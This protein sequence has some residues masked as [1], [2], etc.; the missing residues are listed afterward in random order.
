MPRKSLIN[1]MGSKGIKTQRGDAL[2]QIQYVY[3]IFVYNLYR[4][5]VAA[6]MGT[7]LVSAT[8]VSTGVRKLQEKIQ[9]NWR[10]P[11]KNPLPRCV[12][13]PTVLCVF[14]SEHAF[15]VLVSQL[16][17]TLH[18]PKI[19]KDAT[20]L[21]HIAV[22][23]MVSKYLSKI[24][25]RQ[26]IACNK[27]TVS[28]KTAQTAFNILRSYRPLRLL[29]DDLPSSWHDRFGAPVLFH[30]SSNKSSASNN[31]ANGLPNI[32]NASSS[33]REVPNK[34][35]N[36]PNNK[37]SHK[38]NK[39]P[40][41]PNNKTPNKPNNKNRNMAPS[42]DERSNKK[43]SPLPSSSSS[44][45][46][47]SSASSLPKKRARRAPAWL[48]NYDT[49]VPDFRKKAYRSSMSRKKVKGNGDIYEAIRLG[50]NDVKLVRTQTQIMK[51]CN[52]A[53]RVLSDKQKH[54][55]D[56]I[57]QAAAIAYKVKVVIDCQDTKGGAMVEYK[58][59]K[60][61]SD[62][63]PSIFLR[64]KFA[65]Q[66]YVAVD[67]GSS[68]NRGSEEG[69]DLTRSDTPPP[70]SPWWIDKVSRQTF[71]VKRMAGDGNCLFSALGSSVMPPLTGAQV[72]KHVT[73]WLR[74]RRNDPDWQ[75]QCNLQR[76]NT[77]RGN[78]SPAAAM[79]VYISKLESGLYGG[80]LEIIVFLNMYPDHSVW[81]HQVKRAPYLI[82]LNRQRNSQH[83]VHLRL[84]QRGGVRT[85]SHGDHYDL[86][87]LKGGL[88]PRLSSSP[89][90]S[91]RPVPASQQ[92]LPPILYGSQTLGISTSSFADVIKQNVNNTMNGV[93]V[94]QDV[95]LGMEQN[96][97]GPKMQDL[98][99]C[100]DGEWLNDEI[101]NF[102]TDLLNPLFLK[103]QVL[104]LNTFHSSEVYAVGAKKREVLERDVG[105][106]LAGRK[107]P[108][109]VIAVINE[110]NAHWYVMYYHVANSTFYVLDSYSG[111]PGSYRAKAQQMATI[112][113]AGVSEV[114]ANT[115]RIEVCHCP[116]QDDESSCGIWSCLALLLVARNRLFPAEAFAAPANYQL[117]GRRYILA[118]SIR[119][120][121]SLAS[122]L[123][124]DRT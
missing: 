25:K 14:A 123:H 28:K 109:G 8:S 39:T 85:Y 84:S 52:A 4:Q 24:V 64:R 99:R 60:A 10:I 62:K 95:L 86:L 18:W 26:L 101:I 106:L 42:T 43:A 81:I 74:V 78:T 88:T 73:N 76:T 124:Q 102:F 29:P 68:S 1:L 107:R 41:K 40:N 47:A 16:R 77:D 82:Q 3:L 55:D 83:Q 49:S 46:N 7:G 45:S 30:R 75:H 33:S 104:A 108:I 32:G 5:A 94:S 17:T 111:T 21:M 105:K 53:M 38:P 91:S 36:K 56:N 63:V 37:T 103:R 12:N 57:L 66:A 119:H 58:P 61:R 96:S 34:K 87:L 44:N 22:E 69:I 2:Q 13:D 48:N 80:Q 35:H 118:L 72:R 19:R 67:T 11:L 65:Y 90:P 31:S 6:T 70:T 112:I 116:R 92:S 100:R 93:T 79:D 59:R 121:L 113:N 98:L 27:R 51:R 9:Q 71:I 54:E 20:R 117:Q 110:R 50:L 120:W 114:N 97:S 89:S 115:L 122:A 15:R 23:D